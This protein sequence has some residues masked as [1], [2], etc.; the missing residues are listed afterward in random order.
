MTS[1]VEIPIKYYARINEHIKIECEIYSSDGDYSKGYPMV[2][3]TGATI[4]GISE[5]VAL[6]L[7][8]D[9]KRP[10]YFT[11]TDTS[12]GIEKGLPVIEIGRISIESINIEKCK[13]ICNKYFDEIDIHGVIGLDFL[14]EYNLCINF[15]KR[16]IGLYERN[17]KIITP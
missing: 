13:M 3:D 7:G 14:T 6:Q 9:T 8:Y 17:K 2:L 5:D 15:D 1:I 12:G 11:D 10:L 16:Y 4:S